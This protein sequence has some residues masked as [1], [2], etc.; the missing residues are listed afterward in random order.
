VEVNKMEEGT[1][2]D[3]GDVLDVVLETGGLSIGILM[4]HFV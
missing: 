3:D 4:G 1:Y 2:T